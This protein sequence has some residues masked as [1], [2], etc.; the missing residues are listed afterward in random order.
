MHF[1]PYYLG[2]LA[3]A[4]Y[5]IGDRNDAVVIDP[6]RD[7]DQYL[8]DAAALGLTIRHVIET[9]L[10]ADFVSG[11]VELAGR[12]G[13]DIWLGPGS[14]AAFAHR[15][16]RD[17][18][19]LRVGRL[20][21]RF[22]ETPGHTPE[23]ISILLLD[24]SDP[25]MIFTGD[26]LFAGDVGRPDLVA[27]RGFSAAQMASMLYDSLHEKILPLPD[28][29]EVWPAHGAGSACGRAIGDERSTTVGIQRRVNW[30]LADMSREQFVAD[31]TSNLPEVPRYFTHDAALNR[32]GA[33]PVDQLPAPQ[34]L[35]PEEVDA[36]GALVLDVREAGDWAAEHVPGSLDIGL[37]G[38]FASWAGAL[39]SPDQP[40]VLVAAGP[41]EEKE[42]FT[43]LARVGLEQVAGTLSLAAWRAAGRR[44]AHVPRLEPREL[45]DRMVRGEEMLVIDV[46]R[47]VEHESGHIPGARNIPVTELATRLAELDPA[48]PI[49]VAC[50][51]SYRS[52]AAAG[53]LERGG[54]TVVADLAG[55]VSAWIAAGLPVDRGAA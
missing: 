3:H 16:A 51:S 10:H 34:P 12:T 21:L 18:D 48:V 28:A 50:A 55:G 5:L 52:A 47:P 9:H 32:Q 20:V 15:V 44:L 27:S 37:H 43:R 26:T 14:G 29:V 1:R 54:F 53:I 35:S 24:S 2:C 36:S 41:D 6:Q 45:A 13:A 39:V 42:A 40:I 8:A 33:R 11:H 22:L 46:R 38:A 19:E 31:L 30:A 49:A 7:V 17:G 23:S 4:S 25:R